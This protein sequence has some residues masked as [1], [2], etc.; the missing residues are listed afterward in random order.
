MLG[1]DRIRALIPHAGTMCL[2]EEVVRWDARAI[3]CRSRSHGAP[4]NPLRHDGRIGAICGV[5]YGLQAMAVHGA[6]V[7]GDSQPV[8]YLVR[9]GEVRL[10]VGFLDEIGP[11]LVVEADLDHA[12]H[13][14]QRYRF[15]LSGRPGAPA[16]SGRATIMLVR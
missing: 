12:S 1:Q 9:V 15:A 5:E 10:A 14:A 8:G 11:E 2:L 7:S 16:I 6:L 4:D 13:D 3:E